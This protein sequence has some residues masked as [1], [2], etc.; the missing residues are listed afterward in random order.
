MSDAP[1]GGRPAA[2]A[3]VDDTSSAPT[4]VQAHDEASEAT[5]LDDLRLEEDV[6]YGNDIT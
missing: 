6:T 4:D 5:E 2:P 1:S 3:S